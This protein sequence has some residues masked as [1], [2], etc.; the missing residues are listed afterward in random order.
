MG[1]AREDYERFVRWL[2]RPD[3]HVRE[4]V[5]RFANMILAD[6]D[7]IASAFRQHNSRSIRLAELA[8]RALATTPTA[9]PDTSSEIAARPWPW[10]RLRQLTVGPFRGFRRS[11][12]FD[13]QKRVLLF[14]GPNGSGKSSLCEALEHALLGTVQ[15]AETRRIEALQYFANIHARRF[16]APALTAT[17]HGGRETVV[18]ADPNTYRFCFVEK[19]RIDAFA[20]MAARPP[21]AR[22]ELIATLFGMERFNEFA[23]HFNESMDAALVCESENERTL[24]SRRLVLTRDQQTVAAEHASLMQLD[25][26]EAAFAERC[27]PGSSYVD[28]KA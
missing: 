16:V 9:V 22:T 6:F 28:L 1:S 8:R 3:G 20:R 4:D 18:A 19:N 15:E 23:S 10:R 25:Q 13:L 11:E 7:G 12:L 21:A 26:E 27:R 14:F 17:D 24:A 5:A 2:H